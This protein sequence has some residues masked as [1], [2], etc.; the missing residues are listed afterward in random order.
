MMCMQMDKNTLAEITFLYKE[1]L[2]ECAENVKNN[3]FYWQQ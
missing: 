1:T 2:E 3:G